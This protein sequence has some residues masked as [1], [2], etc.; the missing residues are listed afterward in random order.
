[1]NPPHDQAK[2]MDN[3]TPEHRRIYERETRRE[4]VI[5]S[6]MT[7]WETVLEISF[8]FF[9]FSQDGG[10]VQFASLL[11]DYQNIMFYQ[12]KPC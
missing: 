1:M 8:I 5:Q 12:V 9:S 2:Q 4:Q 6:E 11:N 3:Y 7:R 10:A